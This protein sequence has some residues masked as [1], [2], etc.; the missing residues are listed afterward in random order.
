MNTNF[1]NVPREQDIILYR[2]NG[3][4][5]IIAGLFFDKWVSFEETQ[6]EEDQI[7]GWALIPYWG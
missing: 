1:T 3:R 7:V 6:I 2:S 4:P 5:P